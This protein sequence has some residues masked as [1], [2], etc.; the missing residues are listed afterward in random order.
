M[1]NAHPAV[2]TATRYLTSGNDE[3]GVART[4]EAV[5]GV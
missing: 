2:R 1:A 5:L 3:D 4:I